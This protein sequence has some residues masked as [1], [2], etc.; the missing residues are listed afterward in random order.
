MTRSPPTPACFLLRLLALAAL[1]LRAPAVEAADTA[2]AIAANFS[3]AAREI[4]RQF[5]ATRGHRATLSFGSTGQLFTQIGQ[6]APFDVFLAADQE[7][8]RLAVEQGLALAETRFTYAVGRLVLYSKDAKL[9]Q[10]EP[11]LRGGSFQKLAIA[12]PVT[13]PYGAAAVEAMRKLGV[14]DRLAA[15]LVQGNDIAQTFQFVETQNAELGFVALAQ[16]IARSEGSRWLVPDD[17][18]APIRQDAVLLNRGASSAAARAFL[19][20]L[21]GPEAR[22]IVE[23]YGYGPAQ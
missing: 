17:L 7:R 8:P 12:N 13:A 14:Y 20:F 16:V 9:V 21:R 3:D 23:K 6:G 15:K 5:E 2:L 19:D 10:G 4:A 18:H 22:A 1:L 11:T